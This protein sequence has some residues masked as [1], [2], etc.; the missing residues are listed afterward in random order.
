MAKNIQGPASSISTIIKDRE[1]EYLLL[2]VKIIT[3]RSLPKISISSINIAETKEGNLI[4][5]PRWVAESFVELGFA[6][7]QEESFEVEMLQMLSRERIQSSNQ[8]STINKDFYLKLKRHL[9][10]LKEN[11]KARKKSKLTY[12]ESL[13]KA[14]DLVTLRAV[15]LLPL[16]VG[17]YTPDLMKKITPEEVS[18]F[19]IIRELVQQWKRTVV[20]GP[21]DE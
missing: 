11:I 3:K 8:L 4:E 19:N 16:T 18:L 6:E 21:D 14:M 5:V 10:C 1:M 9:E 13:M 7:I 2:P 15:K 20:E 12:D 17:E